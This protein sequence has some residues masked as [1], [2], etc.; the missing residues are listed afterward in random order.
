M[1]PV[2]GNESLLARQVGDIAVGTTGRGFMQSIQSITQEGDQLVIS[3]PDAQLSDVI[4]QGSLSGTVTLGDSPGGL[5]L[6]SNGPSTGGATFNLPNMSLFSDD[7]VD[8]NLTQGSLTLGGGIDFNVN[9]QWFHPTD[10]VLGAHVSVDADVAM[11]AVVHAPLIGSSASNEISI[12]QSPDVCVT[13]DAGVPVVVCAYV[14]LNLIASVAEQGGI[15]TTADASAHADLQTSLAWHGGAWEGSG[16]IRS[17]MTTQGPT[18]TLQ[19]SSSL[20]C[21]VALS[22]ELHVLVYGVAGPFFG[23]QPYVGIRS[24]M[25]SLTEL[26]YDG[27][28]GFQVVAGGEVSLF[29]LAS[30]QF[31]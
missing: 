1:L 25:P 13:V 3:G 10:I 11:D 5:T 18:V 27:F 23:I 19:L 17:S 4:Q 30:G 28:L 12:G 9:W 15:E 20:V 2:A 29:G 6:K 24:T 22:G 14:D 26:D 31:K 7:S 21:Q 8:V 16:N